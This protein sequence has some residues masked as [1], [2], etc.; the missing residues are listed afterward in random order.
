[1][2]NTQYNFISSHDVQS[3][4]HLSQIPADKQTYIDVDNEGCVLR[5]LYEGGYT[6]SVWRLAHIGSAYVGSANIENI[7]QLMTRSLL[8]LDRGEKIQGLIEDGLEGL[9][10]LKS[11]YQNKPEVCEK[12]DS[13]LAITK[14]KLAKIEQEGVTPINP[15]HMP[16]IKQAQQLETS[17]LAFEQG[18]WSSI[19]GLEY[20]NLKI[21]NFLKIEDLDETERAFFKQIK[22]QFEEA[23]KSNR[24]K[25][26]PFP[27]FRLT[28]EEWEKQR[29]EFPEKL[30][31]DLDQMPEEHQKNIGVYLNIDYFNQADKYGHVVAAAICKNEKGYCIVQVNAGNRTFDKDWYIKY[32]FSWNT[33]RVPYGLTIVEFGPFSRA[34]AVDFAKKAFE[35]PVLNADEAE[36]NKNYSKLWK[37]ETDQRQPSRIPVRRFQTSGNCPLRTP[38]EHINFCLQKAGKVELA[39]KFLNF[40]MLRPNDAPRPEKVEPLLA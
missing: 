21:D 23:I 4:Q 34:E 10:H 30:I 29:A 28:E 22:F 5:P 25:N 15:Y 6:A 31:S 35:F 8:A 7:Q 33:P 36:I 37:P 1:M 27:P 18:L 14:I 26:S 20:L 19:P 9:V 11:T 2:L 38:T 24:L 16:E 39:N 12:I 3:L 13:I 17:S 40:A 32:Q